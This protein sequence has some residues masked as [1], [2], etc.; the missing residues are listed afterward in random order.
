METLIPWIRLAGALALGMAAL[1]F[2]LPSKLGY[3]E[4]L[5][6]LSP[7]VRQV[8]VVHSLYIVL[9]LVGMGAVCLLLPRELLSGEALPRALL[10]FSALVWGLRLAL[11]LLYYDREFQRR[12]LLAS[13]ALG[14]ILVYLSGVFTVAALLVTA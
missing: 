2:V 6:R 7:L 1:N 10:G 11:Q 12:N 13:V 8:F 9:V 14:V 3:R 5:A 4:N